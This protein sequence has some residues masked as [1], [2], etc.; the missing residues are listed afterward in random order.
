[1]DHVILTAGL[2]ELPVLVAAWRLCCLRWEKE[3]RLPRFSVLCS[4]ET[5]GANDEAERVRTALYGRLRKE[6]MLATDLV[7]Q[8]RI[9]DPYDPHS[10]LKAVQELVRND[11]G[12][13]RENYSFHLH[14]TGGTAAMGVN[15]VEALLV[16]RPRGRFHD[17]VSYLSGRDHRI[18]DSDGRILTP[19]N[20]RDERFAWNLSIDDMGSLHRFE[21]RGQQPGTE[22]LTLGAGMVQ[23]LLDENNAKQYQA[24]LNTT[25]KNNWEKQST[26]EWPPLQHP[27]WDDITSR[28][29]GQ[30][31]R[32]KPWLV[33]DAS[34]WR[35]HCANLGYPNQRLKISQFLHHQCLEL[36]VYN[37]LDHAIRDLECPLTR[38]Y[39]NVEC[40]LPGVKKF[41]IDVAAICGYELIAISCS[42]TKGEKAKHK[43]FEIMHRARQIGGTN[44]CGIVVCVEQ[45]REAE[46]SQKDLEDDIGGR[47]LG[48]SVL[49]WGKSYVADPGKLREKFKEYLVDIGW[50]RRR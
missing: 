43:G 23:V 37:E 26:I 9:V 40:H 45:D 34:G 39:H 13:K 21:A 5:G 32:P 22:L 50:G 4:S 27:N 41:Q 42:M 1:M 44:A 49:I 25:W 14:F 24:W 10:V 12:Y 19:E 48:K 8:T 35:I 30:F 31:P 7:W 20:I 6:N 16:E 38:R 46:R 15:S 47:D 18:R 11:E 2:N 33:R 3:K 28:I 17:D 36:M 29:E